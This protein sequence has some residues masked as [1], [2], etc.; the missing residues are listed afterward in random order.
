MEV[1]KS[2]GLITYAAKKS[3]VSVE[4]KRNND[5]F[6]QTTIGRSPYADDTAIEYINKNDIN[7]NKI[8]DKVTSKETPR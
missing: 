6:A 3:N 2:H 8:Y 7:P 5:N 4:F 1:Q